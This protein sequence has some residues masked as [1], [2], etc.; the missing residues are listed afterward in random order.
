MQT[1]QPLKVI[2]N[3]GVGVNVRW[4]VLAEQSSQR[5]TLRVTPTLSR[6]TVQPLYRIADRLSL[7]LPPVST[8]VSTR[9]SG[10]PHIYQANPSALP[11]SKGTGVGSLALLWVPALFP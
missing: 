10:L 4:R 2:E 5:D 8:L 11:M 3:G 7:R 9:R 1:L 6:Q